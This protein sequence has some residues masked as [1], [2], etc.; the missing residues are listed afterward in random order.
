MAHVTF[1]SFKPLNCFSEEY[2]IGLAAVLALVSVVLAGGVAVA[3]SVVAEVVLPV[4]VVL[5]VGRVSVW[6]T[7]PL[8]AAILCKSSIE[9]PLR[10]I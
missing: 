1:S 8:S 10:R 9:S 4:L 2:R 5:V 7:S 6:L 3:V